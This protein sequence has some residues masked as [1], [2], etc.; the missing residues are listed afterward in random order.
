MIGGKLVDRLPSAA[1]AREH[2]AEMMSRLPARCLSLFEG[3][4][5]WQVELSPELEGLYERV[6]NG[7]SA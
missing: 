2:A 4:D 3:E 7:V 1:E 6:R 5:A